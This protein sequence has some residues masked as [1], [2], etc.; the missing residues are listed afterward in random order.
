MLVRQAATLRRLGWQ[1]GTVAV[2]FDAGG[3]AICGE[4]LGASTHPLLD[5]P[6]PLAAL[7]L[8]HAR[9]THAMLAVVVTCE[10]TT[11]HTWEG[12]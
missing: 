5:P 10:W 7:C 11:G 1:P 6:G 2:V 12:A 3:G 9:A 8:A 4:V